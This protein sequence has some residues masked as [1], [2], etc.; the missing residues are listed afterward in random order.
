M[1]L[2]FISRLF[3]SETV[4]LVEPLHTTLCDI[5]SSDM[6]TAPYVFK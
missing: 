3:L 2:K 4:C 5:I 6:I 1:F